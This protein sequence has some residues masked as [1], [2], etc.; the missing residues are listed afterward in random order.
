MNYSAAR[1]SLEIELFS[2]CL[3]DFHSC[4]D[5]D[6]PLTLTSYL[7]DYVCERDKRNFMSQMSW[8]ELKFFDFA[9][10]PL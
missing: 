10:F 6:F 9:T 2:A 1:T 4:Q 3:I 7:D 5:L 8:K